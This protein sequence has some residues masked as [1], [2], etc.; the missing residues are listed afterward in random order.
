MTW[1]FTHRCQVWLLKATS[2]FPGV[3]RSLSSGFFRVRRKIGGFLSVENMAMST[4]APRVNILG[5]RWL[6]D[7]SANLPRRSP[8][9]TSMWPDV[10]MMGSWFM[11]LPVIMYDITIHYP[12][13]IDAMQHHATRKNTMHQPSPTL[14]HD[15]THFKPARIH[16]NEYQWIGQWI[17][18]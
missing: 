10:A 14:I 11:G 15:W 17:G 12:M 18:Q 8:T 4:R 6:S 13:E 7:I 9:W 16:I 2:S 3:F 5:S 1:V